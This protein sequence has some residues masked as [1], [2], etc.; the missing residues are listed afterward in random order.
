[1]TPMERSA[2]TQS[3]RELGNGETLY[4][5]YSSAAAMGRMIVVETVD[6]EQFGTFTYNLRTNRGYVATN[7][8]FHFIENDD[9]LAAILLGEL[10]S[11][12]LEL[13]HPS[14][15][16]EVATL[17]Q[18]VNSGPELGHKQLKD[19]EAYLH[20]SRNQFGNIDHKVFCFGGIEK[21]RDGHGAPFTAITYVPHGL[22]DKAFSSIDFATG[23]YQ[24]FRGFDAGG[25]YARVAAAIYGNDASPYLTADHFRIL[26]THHTFRHIER[27]HVN[28]VADLCE[29]EWPHVTE[30][31]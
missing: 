22:G 21:R 11:Q 28:M 7:R 29:P 27:E 23:H 15:Y 26:P 6:H 20:T 16:P 17:I 13:I 3:A 30:G 14:G 5:Q 25:L 12:D 18:E 19:G 24:P 9:T 31:A 4:T 10:A 1:M 2:I 8:Q